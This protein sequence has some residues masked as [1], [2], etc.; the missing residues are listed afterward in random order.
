MEAE[1]IFGDTRNPKDQLRKFLAERVCRSS[2]SIL[3][4]RSP[5]RLMKIRR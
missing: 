1:E 5:T 3:I 4:V 2:R